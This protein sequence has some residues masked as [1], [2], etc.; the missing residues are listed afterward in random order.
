MTYAKKVNESNLPAGPTTASK[1]AFMAFSLIVPEVLER[2][3][4]NDKLLKESVDEFAE[5]M[6]NMTPEK[7][8]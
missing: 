3:L 4:V 5:K 1:R 7:V 2:V 6:A 8:K